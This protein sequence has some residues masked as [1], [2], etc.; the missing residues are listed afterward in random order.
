MGNHR[1]G[2]QRRQSLTL[3]R[4]GQ[5]GASLVIALCAMT[6]LTLILAA[7]S[8]YANA[9][10]RSTVAVRWV[11]A[12]RRSSNATRPPAANSHTRVTVTKYATG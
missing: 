1:I 2:L 11:G 5:R 3:P 6:V 4:P 7:L 8:L 10:Q 12:Q 9:S